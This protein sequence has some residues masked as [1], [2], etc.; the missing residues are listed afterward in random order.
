[1]HTLR[2]L[3]ALTRPVNGM[4]G[5][6]GCLIGARL[7]TWTLPLGDARLWAA[8]VSIT[9]AILG[10][11]AINDAFDVEIDRINRPNRPIPSGAATVRQ[12]IVLALVL[13]ALA[14]FV[15]LLAGPLVALICLAAMLVN[16]LYSWKLKAI[17]LLGNV[18]IAAL[19]V[20]PLALG[21]IALGAWGQLTI[22]LFMAGLFALGREIV[23]DARDAEGDRQGGAL[24]IA[25]RIGPRPAL[26]LAGLCFSAALVLALVPG[27]A[28]TFSPA[29]TALVVLA[30]VVTVNSLARSWRGLTFRHLQGSASTIKVMLMVAMFALAI[31]PPLG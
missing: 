21:G 28:G 5:F 20:V 3:L 11:D 1:M 31:A 7:A 8:A 2:A 9:L 13:D 25:G 10:A 19:F 23:M 24:S 4:L 16:V 27:L 17:P 6:F 14:L 18:T 12:A 30:F 26:L 22:P 29:Y 15:A